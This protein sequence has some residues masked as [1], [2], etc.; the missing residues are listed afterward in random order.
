MNRVGK[1][2]NYA[3]P[4]KQKKRNSKETDKLTVR[5]ILQRHQQNSWERWNT[6][7][8]T[9]VNKIN[10]FL[11]FTLTY[12]TWEKSALSAWYSRLRVSATK[13]LSLIIKIVRIT[14]NVFF[15]K[16]LFLNWQHRYVSHELLNRL[17]W[18]LTRIMRTHLANLAL[19]ILLQLVEIIELMLK[20]QWHPFDGRY[21]V[22]HYFMLFLLVG[23]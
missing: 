10:S 19:N 16:R 5:L 12:Q 17:S 4:R 7:R 8:F 2:H 21:F 13:R 18:A 3:R 9:L 23:R 22:K 11:N 6:T 15:L 1:K 20:S 14:L